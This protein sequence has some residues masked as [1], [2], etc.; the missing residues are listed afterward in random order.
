MP[1]LRVRA[2]EDGVRVSV[3]A[4]CEL[5]FECQSGT[6]ALNYCEHF[7]QALRD[8]PSSPLT[9]SVF[10]SANLLLLAAYRPGQFEY[11]NRHVVDSP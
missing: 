2:T 10:K 4:A 3:D 9:D 7:V 5:V 8:A 6:A 1:V 11:F